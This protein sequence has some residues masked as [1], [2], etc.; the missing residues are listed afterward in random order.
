MGTSGSSIMA[1]RPSTISERLCGAKLVAM[2]TAIPAAPF[3]SKLGTAEGSTV[4]SW[5]VPSKF[6]LKSA[7]SLSMSLSIASATVVSRAS[8]YR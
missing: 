4:G 8:V 2:P 5:M 3:T 6:S 1:T 7:V